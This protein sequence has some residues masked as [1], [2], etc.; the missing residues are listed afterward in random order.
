MASLTYSLYIQ[1]QEMCSLCVAPLTLHLLGLAR[2]GRMSSGSPSYVQ[3]KS[4]SQLPRVYTI[5]SNK[6]SPDLP[7]TTRADHQKK[8]PS[9]R[10]DSTEYSTHK[11]R[12]LQR[13]KTPHLQ[14]AIL[15]TRQLRRNRLTLQ[16]HRTTLMNEQKNGPPLQERRKK[17]KREALTEERS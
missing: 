15:R 6:I 1:A 16:P 8:P 7:P 2:H 12:C 11:M 14:P 4:P 3:P 13:L 10:R 9:P 5:R 17:V